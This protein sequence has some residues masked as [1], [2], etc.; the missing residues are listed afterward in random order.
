MPKG[1]GWEIPQGI[2][3]WSSFHWFKVS[4][5][6]S[7]QVVVLCEQPFWYVG[8]Y[9]NSRMVP[10]NSP[11]CTFCEDGI[12]QQMR[13]VFSVAE[14]STR[15]IGLLELSDSNADLIRD[16]VA[17]NEGLRGMH[18]DFSKHTASVKSRTEILFLEQ[19]QVAW[20]RDLEAPDMALALELSWKKMNVKSPESVSGR[21]RR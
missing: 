15:R 3:P 19:D 17:R 12:G 11:G 1:E 13:Y 18:L 21:F 14:D 10:C 20:W 6:R 16:W 7:L 9:V 8:H 2:Q 5:R 4:A